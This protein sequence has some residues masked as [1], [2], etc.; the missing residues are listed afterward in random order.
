MS[1]ER[2]DEAGPFSPSPAFVRPALDEEDALC[3][4]STSRGDREHLLPNSTASYGTMETHELRRTGS[5]SILAARP[6]RRTST[7]DSPVA[8]LGDAAST[9]NGFPEDYARQRG[10]GCATDHKDSTLD[11]P[12]ATGPPPQPTAQQKTQGSRNRKRWLGLVWELENK[13]AVARDHLAGERT[14]LAWLRTSLALASIGIG[15]SRS[16]SLLRFCRSVPAL[17]WSQ[18]RAKREA[19]ERVRD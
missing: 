10:A 7:A 6:T 4:R 17:N 1:S 15:A 9:A 13:G 8:G 2:V 14:F 11:P 3:P 12:S 16:L 18:E 5:A 19:T